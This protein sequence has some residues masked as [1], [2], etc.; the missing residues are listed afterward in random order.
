[1]SENLPALRRALE[2]LPLQ[3]GSHPI[4]LIRDHIELVKKGKFVP[5]AV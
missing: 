5:V 2:F 1:M 3:N 4:T